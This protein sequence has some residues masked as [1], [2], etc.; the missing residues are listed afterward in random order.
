MFTRR[1]GRLYG[2][3][4]LEK[5]LQHLHVLVLVALAPAIHNYGN[6]VV[7]RVYRFPQLLRLIHDALDVLFNVSIFAAVASQGEVSNVIAC[8]CKIKVE[9]LGG[10]IIKIPSVLFAHHSNPSHG[11]RRSP[12][13]EAL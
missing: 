1:Y 4:Y 11:K 5:G 8:D 6:V 7:A 10:K 9:K 12:V 2:L 13:E 3:P